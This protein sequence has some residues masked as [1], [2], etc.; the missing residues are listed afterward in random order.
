M[1]YYWSASVGVVLLAALIYL[2]GRY[3]PAPGAQEQTIKPTNAMVQEANIQQG[4]AA[5]NIPTEQAASAVRT[6]EWEELMPAE[7]L[8]LLEA[9][10]PI[11]H[12]NMSAS[13]LAKDEQPRANTLKPA[14]TIS[15][16]EETKQMADKK[17]RTWQDALVST[18]TRPELNQQKV[19]IAG[20]IVPL[21]YNAE[22]LLTEFFLV[23]YFGACIHVP[24]PPPNQ[25]IYVRLPKGLPPPDIYTPFWLQGT[26]K[27]ETK[28]NDLGVSSYSLDATSV[29]AYTEE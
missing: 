14:G 7:D 17:N 24:P 20:Y 8:A 29:E 5:E 2:G 11:D 9:M 3:L 28:E 26:L 19:K 1:N 6:L 4:S 15:Q 10:E 25:I 18:R 13:E 22:Q 16:F 12:A 27:I 21:E 23:P